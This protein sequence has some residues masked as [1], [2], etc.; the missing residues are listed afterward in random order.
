MDCEK[1]NPKWASIHLGIH[2]CLDCAGKHRQ[3]GVIYSFVKSI[4]LDAWNQKQLLFMQKGG[5]ARALD[6]F[7]KR[8]VITPNNRH[9]DYKSP[10]VQQYKNTLTEEVELELMGGSKPKP[11]EAEKKAVADFFTE[12][13]AKEE[14]KV[15]IPKAEVVEEVTEKPKKKKDKKKIGAKPI[16]IVDFEGLAF[17]DGVPTEEKDKIVKEYEK[18][19]DVYEPDSDSV[20]TAINSSSF[21][22]APIK[23]EEAKEL[24][25]E[26][27]KKKLEEL[28]AQSNVKAISSE[29]FKD[30]TIEYIFV[31]SAKLFCSRIS[32]NSQAQPLFPALLSSTR[33]KIS[34][35]KPSI[36]SKAP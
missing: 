15:E 20:V 5:N 4:N 7:R 10:I 22:P 9:I 32:I 1:K 6:F 33:K 30:N 31:D 24:T 23:I 19:K 34:P 18:K 13:E 11:Q 2:L 35:L 14:K 36:T 3:Y 8:G 16:D 29:Q 17:D 21:E 27:S 12:M 25:E 28:K 26:E